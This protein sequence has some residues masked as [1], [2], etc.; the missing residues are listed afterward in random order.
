VVLGETVPSVNVKGKPHESAEPIPGPTTEWFGGLARTHRTHIALSLY[1]RDHHLIYNTAVLFA[2]DGRLIGRYRKTCLPHAEVEAGIAPGSDYPVFET[3]FGRVGLMVCYD[4][5][6]PEV[7]RELASRGAEVIAWPVWGCD[8]LLARARAAENRVF[9]VSSAYM[10]P[11]D[12]WMLSA[13][14]DR[15]GEP[16]AKAERWGEV[17]LAEVELGRNHVGPYNLGDFRAMIARHRPDVP[18][19]VGPAVRTRSNAAAVGEGRGGVS[20]ERTPDLHSSPLPASGAGDVHLDATIENGSPVWWEHGAG[21]VINVQLQYDHE[22][23]APNR[24]AGHIHFALEAMPGSRHTLEFR[25]LANIY[26]GRPGSVAGELK[27]LVTSPDGRVW[28]AVATRALPGDRVQ[29]D[30]EMS[31][32]RV[33]IARVE[34]YRLSDLDRWLAEV[35]RNPLAEINTIGRTVE[36]RELEMVRIGDPKAPHHVLVRARAHPWEAG[37][38]WVACG[39]ADRLLRNDP[40]AAAFRRRYCLWLMPM[41]NKDGVAR[42]R[43]RFNSNGMDLNRGWDRPADPALAPENHALQQ[44]L[45]KRIAEGG[46]PSLALELHNDGNGKLH[47]ARPAVLGDRSG[48]ARL[49]RL[50]SLL[51]KHTWFTEGS[52]RPADASTFTLAD[53]LF[54]GY[55]IDAAVHEFNCHWIAGLGE[56]PLARHW[57]SYGEGLAR[58][59]DEYFAGR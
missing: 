12:G 50:E 51:R 52:V 54:Q 23:G 41:A 47:H 27:S 48:S 21:G 1:E 53:G 29:L 7:A 46:R 58:V 22:R 37:G 5:F 4:G 32:P 44:W 59:L 16:I 55:G 40:E 26:N 3:S 36:G 17:A 13:V 20:A 57:K 28:T 15:R 19:S 6:F 9:V 42:G 30:V 24:A 10:A 33:F 45:R 8:P 43:T 31:G 2:P 18:T 49:D 14:Y 34:P 11:G 39:L 38:N 35:R 25:N 56:R